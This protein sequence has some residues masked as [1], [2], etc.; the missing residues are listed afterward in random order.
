MA[1]GK[2]F[3]SLGGNYSIGIGKDEHISVVSE[4]LRTFIEGSTKADILH[5]GH[6]SNAKTFNVKDCMVVQKDGNDQLVLRNKFVD[7]NV[8]NGGAGVDTLVLPGKREDYNFI[9]NQSGAKIECVET[10]AKNCFAS[11]EIVAFSDDKNTAYSMQEILK[12]S[13]SPTELP[14]AAN[15]NLI[16]L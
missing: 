6:E 3:T 10:G 9:K 16:E 2:D 11:Y 1:Q 8:F 12:D 14:A 13:K 15:K 4:G 7:S 5:I